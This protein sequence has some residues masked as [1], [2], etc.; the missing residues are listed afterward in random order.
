L[1]GM[2]DVPFE[3]T[4]EKRC[5]LYAVADLYVATGTEG[6]DSFVEE[7]HLCELLFCRALP[8]PSCL[9]AI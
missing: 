6:G 5:A 2:M 3:L 8:P 7:A 1:A 9:R 4:A